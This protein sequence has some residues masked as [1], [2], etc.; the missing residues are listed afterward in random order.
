MRKE[1]WKMLEQE[2]QRFP[3]LRAEG[4]SDEEIDKAGK[5]VGINFPEDYREF[6]RRYGGAT[7]GAYPILGLRQSDTMGNTAWSVTSVNEKFRQDDWPSVKHWL[8][9]SVDHG[10]NP[11]GFAPDSQIWISD[12]DFCVTKPIA[13]DFEGFISSYCFRYN[14]P[15]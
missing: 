11:I 3:A 15:T 14:S 5:E 8:I 10:G 7:V 6:L 1:V 13:R 4:V 12:H 9:I 2:F